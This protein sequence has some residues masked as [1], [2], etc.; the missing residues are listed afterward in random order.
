LLPIGW[1]RSV[2]LA[3]FVGTEAILFPVASGLTLAGIM[4]P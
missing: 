2:A 4:L 3:L 1:P